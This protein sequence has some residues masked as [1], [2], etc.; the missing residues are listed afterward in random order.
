MGMV[1]QD[2]AYAV[3]SVTFT[4][5]VN[6]VTD[7]YFER[8]MREQGLVNGL[9]KGSK[10]MPPSPDSDT[11]PVI[12]T[13]SRGHHRSVAIASCSIAALIAIPHDPSCQRACRHEKKGAGKCR[14][15]DC[16]YCHDPAH[17]GEGSRNAQQASHRGLRRKQACEG[18]KG[19]KG[20]KD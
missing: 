16:Q 4:T 7:V 19:S 18:S 11:T 20:S 5:W 9:G 15:Q 8:R 17:I 3:E 13:C 2:L 1:R 10:G 6:Y 12:L 14:K